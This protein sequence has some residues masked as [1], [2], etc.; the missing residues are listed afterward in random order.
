MSPPTEVHDRQVV[1]TVWAAGLVITIVFRRLSDS[2][3]PRCWVLCAILTSG[4]DASCAELSG[5]NGD[6]PA[7]GNCANVTYR[8]AKRGTPASRHGVHGGCR[9]HRH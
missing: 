5:N 6:R 7:T 1:R 2:A 8:S 9:K 4:Y 3:L